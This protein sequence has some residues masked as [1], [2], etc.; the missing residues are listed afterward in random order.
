MDIRGIVDTCIDTLKEHAPKLL[1]WGG[2][3]ACVGG[4]VYGCVQSTKFNEVTADSRKKLEAVKKLESPDKKEINKARIGLVKDIAKLYVGPVAVEALGVTG[5]LVG[6]NA[7]DN[8]NAALTASVASLSTTLLEY[9]GRVADRVGKTVESD[10]F[11]DVKHEQIEVEKVDENGEIKKETES[12]A[13][14]DGDSKG[15]WT[16]YFSSQYTVASEDNFDY[17]DMFLMTKQAEFNR[18]L[19][20]RGRIF[21]NEV[22][23]ELGYKPTIAGQS[24]GWVYDK[25]SPEGDNHIDFRRRRVKH[26]Q[27]NGDYELVFLLDFN[28]DGDIRKHL[29]NTGDFE[30]RK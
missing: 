18:R 25:L 10:I 9:R 29:V 19:K 12:I 4:A 14:V 1:I 2:V 30:D 26:Y 20:T 22:L 5:I 21:L 3:G 8:R 6:C 13:S 16:R 7:F 17:D 28:I 15:D 11:N 24:V 27:S 23:E